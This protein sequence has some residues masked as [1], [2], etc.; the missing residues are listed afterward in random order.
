MTLT[1]LPTSLAVIALIGPQASSSSDSSFK[2][3]LN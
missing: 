2:K 3:L 1:Q